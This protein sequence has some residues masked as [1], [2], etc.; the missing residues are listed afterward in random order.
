MC[1][2]HTSYPHMRLFNETSLH[3]VKT[4]SEEFSNTVTHSTCVM[5]VVYALS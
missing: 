5:S 1:E 2:Y 3:T 4:S